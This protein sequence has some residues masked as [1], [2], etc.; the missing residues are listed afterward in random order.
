MRGDDSN[1]SHW[2]SVIQPHLCVSS[3]FL[4]FSRAGHL[5][6]SCSQKAR[7]CLQT[8]HPPSCFE[9]SAST[10]VDSCFFSPPMFQVKLSSK[11]ALSVVAKRAWSWSISQEGLHTMYQY[12][13]SCF[14]FI[15]LAIC[16]PALRVHMWHILFQW[17]F[18]TKFPAHP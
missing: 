14:S 17:I 7:F 1:L 6:V 8:S 10:S 4:C 13:T 18:M 12:S 3:L 9:Q 11:K 15:S 16:S 5:S 2:I